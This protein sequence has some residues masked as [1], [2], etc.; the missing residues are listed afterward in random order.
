MI[1]ASDLR[2]ALDPA[3]LG[4]DCDLVLDHWQAALLR[5]DAPRVLMNC[6]R[7]SGKS[8]VAALIAISTA[9]T[10]PGALVVLASPSQRQSAE[11]FRSMMVLFRRLPDAPEIRN[12]SVLRLELVNGSR[13]CALPGDSNTVRGY[14][15]ASLVVLDEAARTPDELLAAVRPMLATSNGRLIALSTPAGKRGWF[16]SAWFGHESWFR[17]RVPASECPTISQEFLAEELRELGPQR[18]AEEYNL[19]FLEDGDQVIRGEFFERA[20]TKEVTRLWP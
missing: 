16:H 15:G 20:I 2:R 17:V 14:S 3:L 6:S 10:T 13:V 5:S 8:T 18:F 11:L 12:E 1:G 19:E 4:A 7:Q 9:I